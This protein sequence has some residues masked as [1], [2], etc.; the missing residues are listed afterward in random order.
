[1]ADYA[2]LG[3]PSSLTPFER[4]QLILLHQVLAHLDASEADHH[5]QMVEVLTQGFT[6]E[7]GSTFPVHAELSRADCSLVAEV[8]DMFRVIKASLAKLDPAE[9]AVIVGEHEFA[10]TYQGFDFND[11]RE[12]KM[13]SYVTYLLETDRWSELRDDVTAADGG[14]SHSLTL[15]RYMGRLK[16]YSPLWDNIIATHRFGDLL[17]AFELKQIA[18]APPI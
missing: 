5:R 10:L 11:A 16:V 15:P 3:P 12:G 17:S 2:D 4:Q 14:N 7:Y 9:R 18:E 13:G 8:L 1:M 6:L